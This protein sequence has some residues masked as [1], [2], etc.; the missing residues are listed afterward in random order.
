MAIKTK[1]IL[2]NCNPVNPVNPVKK[3]ITDVQNPTH[4]N[5][6]ESAG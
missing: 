5:G 1:R 3:E 6:T 2:K 4:K